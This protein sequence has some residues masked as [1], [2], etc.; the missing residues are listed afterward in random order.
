MDGQT[1]LVGQVCLT[2]FLI[3][4]PVVSD[5][6]GDGRP[7]APGGSGMS[8]TV[9]HFSACCFRPRWRWTATRAWWVRYV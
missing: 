7:D 6:G 5:P 2:R 4:G 9:P 8:D 1:R 3:S